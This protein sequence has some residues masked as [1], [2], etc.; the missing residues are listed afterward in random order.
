MKKIGLVLVVLGLIF[1]LVGD[2]SAEG[3][4]GLSPRGYLQDDI[5]PQGSFL[6]ALNAKPE[7]YDYGWTG[8]I[9]S[10]LINTATCWTEV[11]EGIGEVTLREN[12]LLGLTWGFGEGLASGCIRGA[13]GIYDMA[14]FGIS[15]YDEPVM[16]PVYEVRHPEEEGFKIVLFEW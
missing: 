15:P 4:A 10:G 7:P 13:A 11:P 14:T 6:K 2:A 1:N 5:I 8:K 9:G 12:L 3:L 16:K